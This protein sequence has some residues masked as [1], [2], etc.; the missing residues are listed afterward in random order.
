MNR[1][2]K[3]GVL[4]ATAL[5]AGL[6]TTAAQAQVD[7][8]T[9]TA[10]K[11]EQTLQE[12]PVAV[13]VI[14]GDTVE[15]AQVRDARDLQFLVPSLEVGQAA[16]STNQ[17][18]SIRSLGTDTFNPGLEASV[19][20]FVDGVFLARQGAAIN[21]FLSLERIEV[22]R[23]PQ[24]TLFGR[25]TP[26]GVISFISK[27]PEFEF[28]GQAE[29]TVGNYDARIVRGTVT[30]PLVEDR[31]AF[32]LDGNRNTRGGF[33]EN[34]TDGREL[35][36]RDRWSLRGQLLWE[37]SE[38]TQV[39]F[40]ADYSKIDEQCCAAPFFFYAP[41]S[42]GAIPA[43]GGT[44]LP[45]NPWNYQIAIDNP[46]FTQNRNTGAS[47]QVDHQFEGFTFTSITA[48]RDYK[49][50]QN[51]DA[52]FTNLDLAGDRL[53]DQRY[54]TFTQEIRLTSD[55]GGDFDWLLG[56]FYYDNTLRHNNQTPYG[57][58][59]RPFADALTG[60]AITTVEGIV[61]APAGLFLAQGQGLREEDYVYNTRSWSV[62]GQVD[63]HLSD[64][65]TLTGGLRYTRE[66]KDIVAD[67]DIV[68]PWSA[69]DLI[70]LGEQV[71]FAQAFQT[72]TGLAPTPANIGAF[73]A[74]FPAQFAALQAFAAAGSTDPAVNPFLALTP[75]Q[76]NPPAPGFT[77]D[78]SEDNISGNLIASYQLS[79]NTNI[80]AS[81]SR[82]FKA[83]GFNVSA[84]AALTGVFEFEPEI[85][86]A[87]ELGAKALIFD[88]TTQ[89]NMALFRQNL[90]DFQANIF[91]GSG[92]GLQNAGEVQLTGFEFEFFSRPFERL[93]L[94]G[95]FTYMFESKFKSFDS[96]ACYPAQTVVAGIFASPADV[97]AGQCGR[98]INVVTGL[99]V[100]TQNSTGQDRQTPDLTASLSAMYT[101]PITDTL[102]AFI[103][104][105]YSYTGARTLAGNFNPQRAVGST[106]LVNASVGFGATDGAWQLQLWVRNLLEEQYQQ[107]NFESVGQPGSI[108]VYPGDPRT[109]GLTL[110]ARF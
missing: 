23:G 53:I 69:V 1:F 75:L 89:V 22:L 26:A 21:D 88:G 43:L 16:S 48:Y 68:D 41:A 80:Y 96:N 51:I 27:A 71:I 15:M 86:T 6:V 98:S 81:Y 52:D 45:P 107:G 93:F 109:Y 40:I 83:G 92:F 62:F 66:T 58:Q 85:S 18:F 108:N 39:R 4:G 95:G 99:P 47:V 67:I 24:S 31:L 105:D 7:V 8:I 32:R 104:A 10:Q 72:Q 42:L 94:S 38:N 91:T 54:D 28:G 30:G 34:L 65:L 25:N 76:F 14:T 61:G 49:E 57:S 3:A 90:E 13:A 87:F 110:R 100:T 64:R 59:L 101:Q 78:R 74:G 84:N 19:G 56:G 50:N 70:G 17:T 2:T 29:V 5:A 35:N 82:G 106:E 9:V 11:R 73:A 20:V 55:G 37:A 103:R 102:E 36:D 77:A 60:G 46:V 97:P 12:V 44:L 33:V 63:W 79:D